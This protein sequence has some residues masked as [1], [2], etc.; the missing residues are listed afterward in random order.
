MRLSRVR[1][2]LALLG[3]LAAAAGCGDKNSTGNS[4]PV[5][6]VVRSPR[7]ERVEGGTD[8]A[9][10]QVTFDDTLSF[11]LKGDTILRQV[12]GGA[13]RFKV[14]TTHDYLEWTFE[15]QIGGNNRIIDLGR[16]PSC[17]I[18]FSDQQYCSNGG[19]AF[20]W[21]GHTNIA[22]PA[23][24]Y[25]E[26]CTAGT[27]PFYL[28]ATWPDVQADALNSYLYHSKLLIAATS[29]ANR[30]ATAFYRPGDYAPRS[31]ISP[32]GTDSTRWRAEVW[33][34]MRYVPVY[35]SGTPP[36]RKTPTGEATR[37]GLNFGL[38]VR[39]TA[40]LP[41]SQPDVLILRFDVR[42]I[43]TDA[44][45]RFVHPEVPAAGHTLTDIFLTPF[46]D[47]DIGGGRSAN[48]ATGLDRANDI[49]AL[50]DNATV[51]P[52]ESLLVAYDQ[53]FAVATFSANY[54]ARPALVG[55]R[56]LALEG[57]GTGGTT[58]K[59]VISAAG[60]GSLDFLTILQEDSAHALISGGR[61]N[62]R[63][64]SGCSNDAVALICSF[65]AANNTRMGWSVGPIPSLAPGQ[66]VTLTVA[67]LLAPPKAGAFTSGTSVAP[68]NTALASTTR[69]IY[70]IAE[71][72]RTLADAIKALRVAP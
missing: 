21:P 14:Q 72:L 69:P 37:F 67:I 44:T 34:D 32:V 58:A 66:E 18:Y 25:G 30:L 23:S 2:S 8:T 17:R 47:V 48:G 50:D 46:T 52:A 29:G 5:D 63:T 56:L 16:P 42:N 28:G 57:P 3:L 41:P 35:P 64:P 65:E 38:S 11:L 24:D 13:H 33:T 59:A 61:T 10:A 43:T 62:T 6:V 60:R 20:Y 39:T 26:F 45:Y 15:E 36:L 31:R 70:L 71:T 4:G 22:C 53:S 9:S 68:Q 19:N 51:F 55:M 1:P 49:E 40:F 12:S 54:K 27:D 7:F